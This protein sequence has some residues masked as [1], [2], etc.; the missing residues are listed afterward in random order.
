MSLTYCLEVNERRK[1]AHADT[2][3]E[4][5]PDD[6]SRYEEELYSIAQ[7]EDG[8]ILNYAQFNTKQIPDVLSRFI[9]SLCFIAKVPDCMAAG[10]PELDC[11]YQKFFLN[12]NHPFLGEYVGKTLEYLEYVLL[13]ELEV[14]FFYVSS[15]QAALSDMLLKYARDPPTSGAFPKIGIIIPTISQ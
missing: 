6:K 7:V 1:Q 11:P 15:V 2:V 5:M 12:N 3:K 13:D 9:D 14:P 4:R 10:W 8:K